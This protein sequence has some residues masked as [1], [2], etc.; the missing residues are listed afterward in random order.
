MRTTG[1]LPSGTV[2]RYWWT[3]TDIDNNL[4]RT[5]PLSVSF[6]DSDYD[7]QYLNQ[8]NVTIYWYYGDDNFA[9]DLMQ[10]SQEALLRL[11]EDTSVS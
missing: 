11:E 1:S 4:Y 9:A 3:A 10:T 5:E 6:D 8:N 7:W 2:V